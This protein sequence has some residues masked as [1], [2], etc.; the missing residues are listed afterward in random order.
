M[1]IYHAAGTAKPESAAHV[2]RKLTE[3]P[4]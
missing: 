4:A 1:L 3:S 2:V